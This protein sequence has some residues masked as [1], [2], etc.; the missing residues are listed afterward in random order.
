MAITAS[1][2]ALNLSTTAGSAGD[3]LAQADPNASLGK[4]VST[5]VMSAGANSLFDDI[6]GAENADGPR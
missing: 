2:I 3:T 1:D 4:Y 5:T 6:S